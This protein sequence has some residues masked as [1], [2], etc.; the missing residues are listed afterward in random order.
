M[1][2][3]INLGHRNRIRQKFLENGIKTFLD[4]EILE[5]LL[6]YSIPRKDTKVIAKELIKKY[7]KEKNKIRAVAFYQ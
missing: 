4:Y 6:T 5:L 1:D 2:E 7:K 3:N